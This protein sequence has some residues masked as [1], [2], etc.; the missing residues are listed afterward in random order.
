MLEHGSIIDPA[1]FAWR[2]SPISTTARGAPSGV[3]K[4]ADIDRLARSSA[5]RRCSP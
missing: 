1:R 2:L 5:P 4:E 3:I